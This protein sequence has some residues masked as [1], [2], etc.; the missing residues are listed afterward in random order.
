MQNMKIKGHYTSDGAGV[1]L[2]RIFANEYAEITDPFL[3]LDNFGSDNPDEYM[4]GFPWHPH[5]GIETVTYMLSG[6]V[7]HGDNIGNKGVIKAGEIQWMTAGSGIIHQEMPLLSDKLEGFQLWVNLPRA[8]K[9]TLP[10]YRGIEAGDI[11]VVEENGM[12]MKIIAG[13]Y[14][15]KSGPV[16]E[17]STEVLYMDV[18][19][20]AGKDLLFTAK[21]SFTSIF[22]VISG[23]GDFGNESLDQ[24]EAWIVR[25]GGTVNIHAGTDF[26]FILMSGMPLR[27]PIAWGGPIVMNTE[28]EL[29]QAFRELDNGTFIKE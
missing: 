23:E 19:L 4:R 7:E 25:D 22:Y 20:T 8:Y 15:G 10:K 26:R 6:E 5:R 29:L 12:K 27:E 16:K 28:K 17:L 21:E 3:L 9:M 11:V 24:G 14:N 18:E 13:E 2:F 1:K